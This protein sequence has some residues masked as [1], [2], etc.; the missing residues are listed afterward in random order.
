WHFSADFNSKK[1]V[2]VKKDL[3]Y[4][5]DNKGDKKVIVKRDENKFLYRGEILP[6]LSPYVSSISLL[7]NE[8]NIKPIYSG[9]KT[10]LRRRFF[11]DELEKNFQIKEVKSDFLE[12]L[13]KQKDLTALFYANINANIKLAILQESFKEIYKEIKTHLLDVFE[14]IEDVTILDNNELRSNIRFSSPA[15]VFC[16]KERNI[17]KYIGANEMS[18]GMQKVLLLLLDL[19]LIPKGGIF[20]IDEY[21]NSL[22][23]TAIDFLPDFL[24]ETDFDNQF[25]ITSHHPYIINN[26]PIEN[27][28]VFHRKGSQVKIKSG[29]ELKKEF[30]K[31]KQKYF[32]QL[33][34]DPFYKEGVE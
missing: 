12:F 5:I 33:I 34:N 6:K 25:F 8:D 24:I 2:I 17:K 15:P 18:S 11:T 20:L 27:W 9:F 16:I 21:E 30:G 4:V 19:F 3:L 22:G 7:Q 26:I 28:I 10:I 13:K 1:E 14:S 32:S 23:L 31:S 29:T